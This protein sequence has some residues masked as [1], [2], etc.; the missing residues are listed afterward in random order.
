MVGF[1]ARVEAVSLTSSPDSGGISP[2]SSTTTTTT[3]SSFGTE[4]CISNWYSK[5]GNDQLRK[6]RE[7]RIVSAVRL[8]ALRLA[9][10]DQGMLSSTVASQAKPGKLEG[11]YRVP[12]GALFTR[13]KVV[14]WR[15]FQKTVFILV[16]EP[17]ENR[18]LASSFLVIFAT[19]LNDHY[20]NEQV[21]TKP[22]EVLQK[23][24]ITLLLLQSYLPSG[25]LLFL[26]DSL[27]KHL[28]KEFEEGLEG[29]K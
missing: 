22:K 28:R 20:K 6:E 19:L 17:E 25:Q 23:P 8:Q 18:Y 10:N 2:S 21:L 26:N 5:E 15:C 14:L 3:T 4:L 24:E 29:K 11:V 13:P 16:C 7:Q 1:D 12:A 27:L 9:R